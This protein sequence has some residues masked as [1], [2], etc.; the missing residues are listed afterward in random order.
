[1]EKITINA[2]LCNEHAK[3]PTKGSSDAAGWDIYSPVDAVLWSKNVCSLPSGLKISIPPGYYMQL[4]SRSGLAFK[5]KVRVIAGTID[6][7]YRGEVVVG[8]Y[9]DSDNDV[10]IKKGDRICQ[11][12]IHKVENVSFEQVSSLDETTRGNG[13]FGSTGV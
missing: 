13:G 12:I 8:L 2:V 10:I 9:N 7:D 6:S 3:L 5:N 4:Y 1:M 11:A